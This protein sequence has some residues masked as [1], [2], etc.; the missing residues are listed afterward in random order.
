[1]IEGLPDL[2]SLVRE[3]ARAA[4]AHLREADTVFQALARLRSEYHNA[5]PVYFYVTD[6]DERLVG[7]VPTRRLLFADPSVLVGEVMRYPVISVSESATFRSALAL[8]AEERLLALPVV[9]EAGRLTGVIDISGVTHA[10]AELEQ[11]ERA[12]EIFHMTAVRM[13]QEQQH[14]LGYALWRRLRWLLVSLGGGIVCAVLLELFAAILVRAI[15]VVFFVPLVVLVAERIAAQTASTSLRHLQIIRRTDRRRFREWRIGLALGGASAAVAA[16]WAA[17]WLRL[18][19]MAGVIACSILAASTAGVAA[20]YSIPR[21][22]RR[23][24]LE[25]RVAMVPTV[26]AVTDIAALSSYL[27]LAGFLLR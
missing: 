24:Q 7:V 21:L 10:I 11:K 8:L 22:L 26:M 2:K 16:I 1:M 6:A 27:A 12:D 23:W 15:A 3:V 25:R 17:S 20:G 18:P 4:P 14:G 9:N 19:A 5:E 13:A